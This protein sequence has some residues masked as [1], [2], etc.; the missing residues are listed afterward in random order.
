MA[1]V[2]DAPFREIARQNGADYTVSEMLTSQTNLWATEKTKLRLDDKWSTS[3]KILQIGGASPDIV[4]DAAIRCEDIGA[5]VIEIN[6][7]CP[8][9]KVCN[10]LA[11]S[12]LLRDEKLVAN[13]LSKVITSVSVPV[14]LKTRLGWDHN[15]KN[16]INIAKIAENIGV[17]GITIHGRTRNDLY[18]GCATYDLIAEVKNSVK[19]PVFANG[20]IDSPEKARYVLDYTKADGL[21]IGRATLGRPWLLQQ[22]KDH[23]NTG[24]HTQEISLAQI[25]TTMIQHFDYLYLHYPE[26]LRYRFTTKHFKWYCQHL[27][28]DNELYKSIFAKFS[29][30]ASANE[31]NDLV[32][33]LFERIICN[34]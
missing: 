3:L 10:V 14:T 28:V 29:V 4:A 22:I 24:C 5:D 15:F 8:A 11:G 33:E 2:T 9:K 25:K 18:N 6:M 21:Y 13:I 7:G 12:A 31:Q 27:D 30:S 26:A 23:V 19:I 17:S 32:N 1:G 16:I 34:L 20:D